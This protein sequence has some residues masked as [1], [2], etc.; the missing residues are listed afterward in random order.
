MGKG[1]SD[2]LGKRFRCL[3]LTD[4]V[5]WITAIGN[6]YAYEDIFVRQLENDGREGDVLIAA[7]V[8]GNSPNVVKAFEWAATNGLRTVALVSAKGGKLAEIA[9]VVLR[10]DSTHYGRVED[11]HM[12]IY[13]MLCYMFIEKALVPGEMRNAQTEVSS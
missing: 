4:N 12:T 8:S 3:S 9:E 1:A 10:I 13:H 2:S 11:C 6:D 5:G 7:S